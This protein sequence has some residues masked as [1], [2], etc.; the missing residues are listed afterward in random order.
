M[1]KFYLMMMLLGLFA[2][3]AQAQVPNRI[4]E[5]GLVW[6]LSYI[7]VKPGK[8]VEYLTFLGQHTIPLW[9]E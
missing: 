1:K 6:R 2:I 5:D 8:S 7:N 9:E 3:G 4:S